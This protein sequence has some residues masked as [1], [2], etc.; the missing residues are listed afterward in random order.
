MPV[1]AATSSGKPRSRVPPPASRIP[2]RAMSPVSSGGVCSS[3]SLIASTIS[4]S[5]PPIAARTSSLRS[6][7]CGRQA[8]D[9][10]T[11]PHLGRL[12]GLKR[13]RRSDRDLDRLGRL[14]AD[15]Q[16]VLGTQVP[17]DRLVHLVTSDAH[18]AR[19]RDA[20]E[21]DDGHLAGAAPDV[22]HHAPDRLCDIEARADRG[23]D[24]LL[25]QVDTT[26]A[27]RKR[28]LLDRPLLD[29]GDPRRGAHDQTGVGPVADRAPCG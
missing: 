26:R 11:A 14:R 6:W 9:Q 12:F 5:G 18:R 16:R 21:R 3:V 15:R 20:T 29:L 17:C 25:D 7:I 1:S 22:D 24:R 13:D 23:R 28:R 4:R 2:S 10:V 27:G 8:G 19:Q